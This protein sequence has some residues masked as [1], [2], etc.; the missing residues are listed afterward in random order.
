MP[1]NRIKKNCSTLRK[2]KLVTAFQAV[3]VALKVVRFR[4]KTIQYVVHPGTYAG[5]AATVPDQSEQCVYSL[6]Q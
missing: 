6:V 1:K 5:I 4:A 2:K 3:M